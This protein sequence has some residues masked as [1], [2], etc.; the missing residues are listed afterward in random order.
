MSN[1]LKK[2]F[3]KNIFERLAEFSPENHKSVVIGFMVAAVVLFFFSFGTKFDANMHNINY[4]TAEQRAEMS[5]LIEQNKGKGKT[6][7][8]VAEGK[9]VDEALENYEKS[10]LPFLTRNDSNV[11]GIGKFFPSKELQ[12][13]KI[14]RGNEFW[15]NKKENLLQN[16]S[17]NAKN[18]G[19][20]ENVFNGFSEILNKNYEVQNFE[21]FEPIYK[22]MGENY[23]S[24]D[25]NKTLIYTMLQVSPESPPMGDIGGLLVF[26]DTSIA[27]KMVSAL[28]DD[29]NKALYICGLL[30]FLFLFLSFCRVEFAILSF[31]PITVGWV[32][33]LGMMNIFGLTFNIVNII[34]ATFIFGQGDDYT[35]FVT[36]GLIYE[37]TYGKKMLAKF[38]KSI[39]LSAAILFIAIGTLIFAKHPAMRSLAELTI[40]GMISVVICAWLLP[41][42]IYRWL[43]YRKG[44]NRLMPIT[45]WNLV[46]TVFAFFIFILCSIVI[47]LAGFFILT[48]GGKTKKHKTLYHS[49]LCNGFKILAKLM[50]QVEHKIHNPN[51]ETFDKPAIIISNHQSHL[52]LLYTLLL[53]PKIITLTNKWVWNC[54]FYGWIIRY[55]DFL[56]IAD[57]LEQHADKLQKFV[58]E[59][60][61]I[62]VFPEG[63]RSPDCKIGRFHKGA[64]Y[65]AEKF[66]LDILPVIIHGIGHVFPKQEFILRKGEVNV[67]ICERQQ[68]C[69][70]GVYPAL[71]GQ[72]PQSP[73][74]IEDSCLCRN[75]SLS[76]LELSKNFRKFYQEKYD[77]IATKVETPEYFVDKLLKSYYYKG[78]GVER[79]MR[80]RLKYFRQ[81]DNRQIDKNSNNPMSNNLIINDA[82]AAQLYALSYKDVKV[83]ASDED[84]EFLEVAKNCSLNP[85]NLEFK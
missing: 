24:I 47:T 34:L 46:K 85:V 14:D 49:I 71:A 5:K 42:L 45:L 36:E 78:A 79:K 73:E 67:E 25:N 51:N 16:I 40:V 53:S 83:I 33:I 69:H 21:Y 75:D 35:I 8:I 23:F 3:S 2:I 60:Y 30:V 82:V 84:R 56:P 27:Q 28:S 70:C 77:E 61:S 15:K 43:V 38:K 64:F 52:D 57:G 41:P 31:I 55:A 1:F 4:M 37:Y 66:G 20:N 54:P 68:V 10:V 9:T 32:C 74:T 59:G 63:T 65:L 50:P 6:V 80:K 7:Y 12:K 48:I 22:G 81:L 13:Q 26:D 11:S 18:Q 62:L 58:D 17:K 76:L 19:F 29:F 44:K 39:I 72:A